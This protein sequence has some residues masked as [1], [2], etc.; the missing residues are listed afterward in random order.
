MEPRMQVVRTSDGVNIAYWELGHGP[1]LI[2]LSLPSS[3]AYREWQMP[4]FRM[5]YEQSASV[6]RIVRYDPRGVGSSDR[7]VSDFSIDALVRDLEAVVARLSAPAIQLAGFA[8][9][10]TVA[11]AYAARHPEMVTHLH[12]RLHG[13]IAAAG[14]E[15][16]KGKLLG[17][18]VL[19][20][21]NSAADAIAVAVRAADAGDA[22]GL[23]LH[24]GL[25]AGD[26]VRE[27]G[28]VHGGPVNVAAR[29]SDAAAAG[30][31][32]V[33]EVVRALARTSTAVVF[34]DRGEHLLKGVAEKHRLYCIASHEQ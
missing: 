29:I 23:P 14:G 22:A 2:N 32:L 31:V 10:G 25:H 16:I 34:E 9:A 8:M 6:W 12:D 15:T 21:F 11:L 18:G 20:V 3:H 24:V 33:S 28:D 30:E 19:A 5:L 1:L 17:D 26:V 27:G 4:A 13:M 7:D